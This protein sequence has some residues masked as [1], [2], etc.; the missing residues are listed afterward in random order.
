MTYLGP[1]ETQ[2]GR[3]E[4]MEDTARVLGRMFDGIE[5][6]G[7]GQERVETLGRCAGVPVW[8]GLTDEWHPTQMLAD[9]LTMQGALRRSRCLRSPTATW[10]TPGTTPPIRSSSPARSSGM[11]V[12]IAAP[13]SLQPDSR[14]AGDGASDW[15]S[16]SGARIT[17]T[18]D[19]AR[20]GPGG[21]LPLH[22]RVAV[23]GRAGRAVGGPDPPPAS[24]SGHDGGPRGHAQP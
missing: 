15:P 4:S 5:Y 13:A 24:V 6:R 10:A 11:D 19:V 9:I 18:E 1:G 14:G 23:D 22:R 7:F 21:R 17:V 16:S 3:K 20:G 2:L 8:N 12:R